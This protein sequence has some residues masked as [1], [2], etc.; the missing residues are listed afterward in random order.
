MFP[1]YPPLRPVGAPFV[2]SLAPRADRL[3]D[4][5]HRDGESA[6]GVS[7]G[8]GLE[9]RKGERKERG[10]ETKREG[11][12]SALRPAVPLLEA[13]QQRDLCVVMANEKRFRDLDWDV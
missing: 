9:E 5:A 3:T 12:A 6:A 13:G 8:Y 1:P 7:G 4:S 10:K 11:I 2:E